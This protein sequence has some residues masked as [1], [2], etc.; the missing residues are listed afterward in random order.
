MIE[1]LKWAFLCY[2]V[3][4]SISF[5]IILAYA[6]IKLGRESLHISTWLG[7]LFFA[8]FWIRFLRIKLI[9]LFN[10]RY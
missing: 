2:C 7:S 10:G 4:Y 9:A 8:L 1:F 6:H 3:G 5:L